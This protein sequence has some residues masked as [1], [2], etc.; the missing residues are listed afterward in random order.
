MIHFSLEY[1]E[2]NFSEILKLALSNREI[3]I[4]V[5]RGKNIK[6]IC[7]EPVKL[8]I[9]N[10]WIHTVESSFQ[11]YLYKRNTPFISQEKLFR[12]ILIQTTSFE[13][14]SGKI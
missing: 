7:E 10:K 12:R 9:S 1:A 14:P 11:A 8:E 6:I 4:S 13:Y 5:K 3:V 2:K